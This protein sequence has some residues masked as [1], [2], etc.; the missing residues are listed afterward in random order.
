MFKS[1]N[2]LRIEQA[3]IRGR[4]GGESLATLARTSAEP[5]SDAVGRKNNDGRGAFVIVC[6][7][8]SNSFPPEYGR[9]GLQGFIVGG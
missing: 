1:G 7:H 3:T 2:C 4:P 8:A 6:D 5:D 9:S